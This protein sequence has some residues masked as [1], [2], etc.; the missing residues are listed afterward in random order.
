VTVGAT[1]Q[2]VPRPQTR[3]LALV[4]YA[5]VDAAL[6]AVTE[7][8]PSQ[9]SAIE[10]MDREM[11]DP[12]NR[13]P[14]TARLTAFAGDS[15]AMLMVEFQGEEQSVAERCR[16]LAG[17]LV[18][19]DA[20]EQAAVWAVRR[21]GIARALG[22][23]AG[24]AKPL[25]FIEDPA[26]PPENLAR[27][28]R[29]VRAVLAR[30]D[31]PAIWYGHASVGCLH[32]RPVLNLKDPADVARMRRI[33][34]QVTDLVL[35]YGGSL[36][37]EHGDGLARSEWN[38][39]MFGDAIYE[40]F[41]R[42]KRAFDP[43]N[44]MNP[45]KV[46]DAPAMT[47]NLR[48]GPAYRPQQPATLFD[49]SSQGGFLGSIEMCNGSGV[50]RRMQG[51]T[52][53]P[54]F[55][56][57]AD[58]ADS[59]RGRANALR[60]ALAGERP[61]EDFASDWVHDVMD[62]C[63]M[64]KAC[65]A[66]CPSNVDM[67]KLKAEFLHHYH[68]KHARP[69]GQRLMARVHRLNALGAAVAPLANW[70]GQNRFARWLLDRLGG[71][72]RRRSLPP[73]AWD[74][75]RRWLRRHKRPAAAGRVGRVMLLDDCFTTFNEPHIGRAAV[76]VLERAG[77]DVEL[78]GLGCCGRAMISKGML[79][80]ARS[81]VAGQAGMLAHRLA[82][83]TAILG[84][85]PSCLL[86]LA[87]EWPALVPGPATRRIAAAAHLAEG[88]L[89][90]QARA[91]RCELDLSPRPGQCVVHGHCHQ[92]ALVGIDGTAQALRLVPQLDVEV[93]DTGC[94]GMAGSFGYEKEHFDLSVRIA[95]LSVLPELRKHED[96]LV[97]APGTSCRHQ[98]KDLSSRRALHPLEVLAEQIV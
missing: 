43:G 32:I 50:C 26:V 16:T 41:R 42:V 11:L 9:P 1:L 78:A 55:R 74:H 84:L 75:F 66:E 27:F 31:L 59:T 57:T 98:I 47:E 82:D 54:S 4:S 23:D 89:A 14:A 85:E 92:K 48:Y 6:D 67:S 97:V 18:M 45:G 44:R 35:A 17:A 15:A 34:E 90:E 72:D 68:Q 39:K 2:L 62:L 53:C 64:C 37:G 21:S 36:S 77:Y 3:G 28:A 24:D 19:L 5:T 88:W 22:F 65:K 80:E 13:A 86:T 69:L 58:E 96:A 70:L 12:R 60:L 61:L 51:G 7:I 29:A 25:P 49:Y 46:V 71:V 56:A 30:E 79:A 95:E 10:L 76:T 83:G 73:L 93:L 40:G 63:L 94:C 52:M 81:L 91:G 38:R 8:L 20:A 33:T 87:D